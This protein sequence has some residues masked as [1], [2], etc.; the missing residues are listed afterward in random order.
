MMKSPVVKALSMAAWA[1]TSVAAINVGLTVLTGVD[2]WAMVPESLGMIVRY[3]VGAAGVYSLM[4]MFTMGQSG[5]G[6]GC[7]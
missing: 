4:L 5:C 3:V 7:K 2:I 1:L 6:C